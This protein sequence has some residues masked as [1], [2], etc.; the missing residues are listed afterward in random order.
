MKP[1]ETLGRARLADGT[2]LTLVRH[3]SEFAI[4]ANG[5]SLM[6][7]R[8]HGSEEALARLGCCRAQTMRCPSVLVGGLGM[9]Y[10]L[11]AALDTLPLTAR[12]L[13][14]ELVPAVVEWNRGPLGM[15]ARHPLDDPRVQVEVGDVT[16]IIR[17]SRARFDFVLLDVD[18]GSVAMTAASNA[19]LYTN[20]GI[21]AARA[22]I[23]PGGILA[24]WSATDDR[25]FER[26]LRA[27]GFDVERTHVPGRL[28]R[29]PR[30]TILIA[31]N[32]DA[33][34]TNERPA[35]RHPLRR[36]GDGRLRGLLRPQRS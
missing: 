13:V 17:S 11:R 31:R 23:R 34:G 1:W 12:V 29:G 30:H 27:G 6:S 33:A 14:A 4:L 15:L 16:A 36:L 19:A 24:V 28:T 32:G 9:G 26:R 22:S 20:Q 3:P 5:R 10:T 8:M 35:A 2:E 7:S 18:N 21:A 25:R